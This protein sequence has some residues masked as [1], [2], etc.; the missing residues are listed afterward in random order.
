MDIIEE[1]NELVHK[2]WEL[3]SIG[4]D[5]AAPAIEYELAYKRGQLQID[6]TKLMQFYAEA[7]EQMR[8]ANM[9]QIDWVINNAHSSESCIL[10]KFEKLWTQEYLTFLREHHCGAGYVTYRILISACKKLWSDRVV[11]RV[12]EGFEAEPVTFVNDIVSLAK[13]MGLEVDDDGLEELAEDHKIEVNRKTG[14]PS[15]G[16]AKG[17]G[18]KNVFRE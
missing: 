1:N 17:G 7:I 8:K 5:P 14:T 6:E 10:A 16:A 3:E 2:L 4:I 11:D 9:P 18:G 12:F 13:S 15:K